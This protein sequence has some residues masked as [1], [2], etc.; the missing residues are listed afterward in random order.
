MSHEEAQQIVDQ[1]L[2]S[3]SIEQ[4][5]T[6]AV[7]VGIAGSGKTSLISRLFREEPPDRYTSTGV[8]NKSLRGLKRH[9]A[10]RMSCKRL[11]PKEILEI[12][13]SFLPTGLP[14]AD[15][16]SLAKNFTEEEEPEPTQVPSGKELSRPQP[17][18]PLKEEPEP[19]QV[20]SGK[21]LTHPQPG[22]SEPEPS[23]TPPSPSPP[24]KSYASQV[25]ISLVEMVQGPKKAVLIEL[26]HMIDT[27]GQPEFME[28]MPSLIHNSNLTLLVLN[29]DQCLD[30]YP[31]FAF[32]KDGIPFK[33]PLPSIRTNRQ[34]I[35][36]LACTLQAKRPTHE[37]R[38]VSVIGTHRD[39]VEKGKLSETLE[40]MN[41]EVESIFKDDE[42]IS[43]PDG[44]IFSVNLL[45]PNYEDEEVLESLRNFISITDIGVKAEVPFSFFMFEHEA[46]KCA[47][48]NIKQ[49]KDRKV[50]ILSFDECEQ[51][52]TRLKMSCEV[53]R[54]A[55]IF[56]HRH[57]IFLYFQH[58]L[59][60]VVFLAPQV[61]LD[62]VNAIVAFRY[63]MKNIAV[64]SK[65]YR[66]FCREGIITEG[67]LH[68][69]S[70]HLCDKDLNLSDCFIPGIYEPQDA[71][72]L[73]LHIYAIAPLS[74]EEPLDKDQPPHTPSSTP[75]QTS[76]KEREYLMMTLLEDKPE[77]DI[78]KYL[79]SFPKVAPLVIHFDS[80]CVPN[81]CFGN[82]ISC[83]ISTYN[84]KVSQ[85]KTVP[86]C[87]AHNIVT[88]S[89]PKLPVT[90][91]LVNYTRHLEIC[92]NTNNVEEEDL[93][94][95]CSSIRKTIFEAITEKVFKLMRFEDLQVE[96]AFLCPCDCDPSH[97][98]KICRNSDSICKDSYIVCSEADMS[99]G[100]LKKQH[101]FWFQDQ[102]LNF[103]QKPELKNLL[104][105]LVKISHK[106]YCLGIQL[107]L[108]GKLDNIKSD[109]PEKSQHC[110]SEMLSTWL[111]VE[112]RATWHTLCAALCSDAV[113]E[114]KLANNLVAKYRKHSCI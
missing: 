39:C 60:D 4:S 84:W 22:T 47:E 20:P 17:G 19:T 24:Q 100:R 111:K 3:G 15:I 101:L 37:G 6:V 5:S 87:L 27:G 67:M 103:D 33:Q 105:E 85:M 53:V 31:H 91:T 45:K 29:L 35:R 43:P 56:F 99:Q 108:E 54:A 89:D 109:H 83:L 42:L 72:K 73:F 94:G 106:W 51:V 25:M 80:G 48:Q 58:I 77:K 69:K 95:F 7:V 11:S 32:Y 26:L 88:L 14:K 63:K 86:K 66:R 30:E 61:P 40:A 102:V 76:S 96:P 71:I 62:F 23:G 49:K 36:Q 107:G 113:G 114:E 2:K 55:L 12:F 112:P 70:L 1:A 97:V 28:I 65:P 41:E 9:I 98:A 93:S 10:T 78:P 90:I 82:T 59:P 79:P 57:N 18:T 8:A 52:G 92:I 13:A 104:E 110:L 21:E 16:A 64:M 46:I 68:V 75:G 34:V 50:M 38:K 44:N 74:N 81:G